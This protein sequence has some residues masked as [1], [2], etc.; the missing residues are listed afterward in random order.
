MFIS[1]SVFAQTTADPYLKTV[2]DEGGN[3]LYFKHQI[4]IAFNPDLINK[5]VIDNPEFISGKLSDFFTQEAIALALNSGFWN[6]QVANAKTKKIYTFLDTDDTISISR[7]GEKRV[8]PKYWATLLVYW[9]LTDT[10][11]ITEVCTQLR[12]HYPYIEF[13]HPNHLYKLCSV[14]NDPYYIK[15]HNLHKDPTGFLPDGSIKMQKAWNIETGSPEIKLGI[16]DSPIIYTHE[17]FGGGTLASSKIKGGKV[18][19]TLLNPTPLDISAFN[20]S[21][22][23]S[24]HGTQVAGIA[25]AIR[26]NEKGIAGVAGGD[27]TKGNTGVSLYTFGIYGEPGVQIPFNPN[28]AEQTGICSDELVGPAITEGANYIPQP[29]GTYKGYGLDI[30]NHS[31]GG[32]IFSDNL[33][34]AIK[35]AAR[36]KCV[37]VCG[38]GNDGYTVNE[39]KGSDANFY[40]ACYNDEWVISVGASGDD[41]KRLNHAAGNVGDFE[42]PTKPEVSWSSMFGKNMDVLAPAAHDHVATTFDLIISNRRGEVRLDFFPDQYS[43]FNGTSA[44][45]PHV[46]GLAGLILS[47]YRPANGFSER[48]EPEDVENLIEQYAEHKA[49]AP[50]LYNEDQGWGLIDPENTLD[51]IKN[52]QYRIL[53][54]NG[55]WPVAQSNMGNITLTI[56]AGGAFGLAAGSYTAQKWRIVENYS[57]TFSASEQVLGYW[58]RLNATKGLKD[59]ANNSISEDEHANY[60]FTKTGNTLAVTATTF[61][62]FV[63]S[64]SK[65]LSYNRMDAT[66]AFSVH[67]FDPTAASTSETNAAANLKLYPNPASHQ[68]NI[69]YYHLKP[70]N[71]E[72][73]DL[74]GKLC[75]TDFLINPKNV[76]LNT[77]LLKEGVYICRTIFENGHIATN[78]IIITQ[79]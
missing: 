76:Q 36:N 62:Y 25:A 56:P 2:S 12:S 68:V 4:I 37:V 14:P 38:R 3:P 73:Y 18:Y 55:G 60:V 51:K 17:D 10:R 52:N 57:H 24:S 50:A 71:V 66:T 65:W 70:K 67:V 23:Y 34:R 33:R 6:D 74:S 69:E 11:P 26:N 28:S 58:P 19:Y 77:S 1:L 32:R 16:Y 30:Q 40:P 5:N 21:D 9:P 59:F 22:T 63:P 29:N 20:I 45:A 31:W 7:T 13:A 15:Q 48:L 79:P 8:I 27:F 78:K 44:A 49:P 75:P 46:A 61:A 53:H 54:F 42:I 72:V 64:Q 43:R 41:K 35:E 47:K 39:N